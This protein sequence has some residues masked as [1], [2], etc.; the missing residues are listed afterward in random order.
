MG[1]RLSLIDPYPPG[2]LSPRAEKGG[3]DSS[4][5]LLSTARHTP[6]SA[7][8]PKSRREVGH[9][10]GPNNAQPAASKMGD[11]TSRRQQPIDNGV[12]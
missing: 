2:P 12:V 8:E 10:F 9:I 6:T 5:S 4:L 11:A 7:I 3:A 1:V